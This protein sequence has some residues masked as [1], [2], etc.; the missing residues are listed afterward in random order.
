MLNSQILNI[1]YEQRFNP[2]HPLGGL[3]ARSAWRYV[4]P[5]QAILLQ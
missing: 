5:E 1:E 3:E 4:S 2:S